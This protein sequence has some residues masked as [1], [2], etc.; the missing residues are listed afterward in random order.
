ME[1]SWKSHGIGGGHGKVMENERSWKNI[2]KVMECDNTVATCNHIIKVEDLF[3]P[4]FL[5]LYYK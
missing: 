5:N 4:M 2:L 3:W 1:K